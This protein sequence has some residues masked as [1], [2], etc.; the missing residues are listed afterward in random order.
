[1]NLSLGSDQKVQSTAS[2]PKETI[3]P[4]QTPFP[5]P[6][7]ELHQ[8]KE[9]KE[10][11]KETLVGSDSLSLSSSREKPKNKSLT[12]KTPRIELTGIMM[13]NPPQAL[14][15]GRFIKVGEKFRGVKVV[16]IVSDSVTFEYQGRKFK[17]LLD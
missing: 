8:V 5:V 13:E 4:N 16:K 17:K 12:K 15:N 6:F 14:I 2:T 11:K 9:Q 10:E 7:F 3:K 1:M